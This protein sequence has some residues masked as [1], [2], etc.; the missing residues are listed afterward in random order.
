VNGDTKTCK[1]R[2]HFLGFHSINNST[3]EGLTTFLLKILED[4]NLNIQ[5]LRGQ[6][7]DNGANMH[8]NIMVYKKEYYQLP[9]VFCSLCSQ[10][11]FSS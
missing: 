4:H 6:S 5:D 10:L 7:Y 8:K 9:N 11:K 3:G 2:E 1:I